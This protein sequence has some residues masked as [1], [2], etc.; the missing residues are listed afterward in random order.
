M[1]EQQPIEIPAATKGDDAVE[2]APSSFAF[3][4]EHSAMLDVHPAH[5]AANSWKEFFVHMATIVLGLLIAI[6]LEQS[7]EWV[8]HSEQRHQLEE[9]LRTEAES[10]LQVIERDLRMQ[11]TEAWFVQ[12][13]AA[14]T[15][16]PQQ[17]RLQFTLPPPPCVPGSVGTAK[18]RYFAP[19]EAVRIA[20]QESGI[21]V[22]LPVEQARIQARLDHNYELL[23]KA[24]DRVA[25]GCEAVAALRL[26]LAKPGS[27]ADQWTMSPEQAEL[28]A[29]AASETLVATKG[30]LF[31]LR[32][33]KLY[34]E[35]IANG[36]SK[37]D[38]NMM[39]LDQTRFEDP[40][41]Q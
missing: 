34:E 41:A 14:A 25:N 16:T 31:R 20:A 24:R 33:S 8:H 22:L 40:V 26:R 37:T 1:P 17:G 5:H 11:E 29:A 6:S 12:A 28:F 38:V 36:E 30:L 3:L 18:V 4:Q 19:S 27:D 13:T 9:D 10:N 39:T 21:L 7:V 15:G 35:S 23:G 32:W 2:L